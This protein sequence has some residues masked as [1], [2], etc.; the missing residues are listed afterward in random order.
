MEAASAHGGGKRAGTPPALCWELPAGARTLLELVL[1]APHDPREF[2]SLAARFPRSDVPPPVT[3]T[4]TSF[5][6]CVY[7]ALRTSSTLQNY[8]MMH[9]LQPCVLRDRRVPSL[10]RTRRIWAYD[11]TICN[12]IKVDST[13]GYCLFL[14]RMGCQWQRWG[15]ERWG[16]L[17]GAK[18]LQGWGGER[19]GLP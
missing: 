9:I 8:E 5:N 1:S 12:L 15:Q 14:H 19:R 13:T 4:Q 18:Q 17:A 16:I 11:E 7:K 10:A 2:S 6:V 3:G